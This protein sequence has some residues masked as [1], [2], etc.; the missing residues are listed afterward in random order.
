MP[1]KNV[2]A[3]ED[4]R[5]VAGLI[6]RFESLELGDAGRMDVIETEQYGSVMLLERRG[7]ASVQGFEDAA[8]F[9]E[10][11]ITVYS[12]GSYD[13]STGKVEL[14]THNSQEASL[15][16]TEARMLAGLLLEAAG[17]R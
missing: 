2:A 14:S 15:T 8:D 1:G 13:E 6:S 5:Q 11:I 4:L 16:R 12:G 9:D 7:A 3:A 10:V 17:E